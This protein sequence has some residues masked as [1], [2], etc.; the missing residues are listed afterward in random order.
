LRWFKLREVLNNHPRPDDLAFVESLCLP[1]DIDELTE[2][3]N[4]F[5]LLIV[6]TLSI[7]YPT[8]D[9][10]DNAQATAQML[11]FRELAQTTNTAIILVQ[12]FG[13]LVENVAAVYAGR[14][15][16]ARG[17]HADVVL[18]L[19]ALTDDMVGLNTGKNRWS[20]ERPLKM[21]LRK[22]GGGLFE[23]VNIEDAPQLDEKACQRW[24]KSLV[25]SPMKR[26]DIIAAAQAEGYSERTADRAINN[27]ITVGDLVKS[28]YGCYAPRTAILP[29]SV[30][31]IA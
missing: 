24:L 31:V 1:R 15:A 29:E 10:N 12:H 16:S 18:N 28:G 21:K 2:I 4:D 14:G 30:G 11:L 3:C 9:E 20:M 7:A 8:R 25:T 5:D 6:D 26:K 27:L 19:E 23:M 13:K 22:A 17:A